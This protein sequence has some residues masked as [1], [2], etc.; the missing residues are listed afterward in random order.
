LEKHE[1][2]YHLFADDTHGMLHGPPADVPRIASTLTVLQTSATGVP[3]SACSWMPSVKPKLFGSDLQST[4]ARCHQASVVC[5]GSTAVDSTTVVR[6]LAVMFDAE[7]SMREH[8]SRVA[9]VCF[10]PLA[11]AA[12]NARSTI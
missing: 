1:L 8:V 7:L 5:A 9:Q 2:L 3:R 11:S 10:F 4:W 6:N 12:N